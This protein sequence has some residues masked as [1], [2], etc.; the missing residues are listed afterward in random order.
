MKKDLSSDIV[1]VIKEVARIR[2]SKNRSGKSYHLSQGGTMHLNRVFLAEDLLDRIMDS[3]VKF[4]LKAIQNQAKANFV[5]NLITML[6]VFLKDT[7]R[8]FH[9][10]W[11]NEGVSKLLTDKITLNDAFLL[12]RKTRIKKE[13]LVALKASFQNIAA[14][15][16][17]FSTLT[18]KPFLDNLGFHFRKVEG[19]EL[20]NY[21]RNWK[22][23]LQ[24]SFELRHKIIHEGYLVPISKEQINLYFVLYMHLPFDIEY[25]LQSLQE[26]D[27]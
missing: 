21:D 10:K 20:R 22:Q 18:G 3:K 6:E 9:G 5:V 24:E 11:L 26:Y 25:Y 16:S 27:F 2:K 17:T 12:A 7:I 15:E 14:I 1:T 19:R 23:V 8:E 13:E 4:D